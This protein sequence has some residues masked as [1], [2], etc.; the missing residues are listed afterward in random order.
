MKYSWSGVHVVTSNERK[1][2]N[3]HHQNLICQVQVVLLFLYCSVIEEIQLIDQ[4][5]YFEQFESS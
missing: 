3:N 1:Y 2:C 5:S 4:N